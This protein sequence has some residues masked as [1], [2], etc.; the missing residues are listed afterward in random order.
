MINKTFRLFISSTFSDFLSER[1]LL[2]DEVFPIVDAY[3]QNRG[4][5]FQ[6]IDLRWGI[7]TE[8]A[9][10]Q[11]TISICLDEVERCTT[12]SPRPNFLVMA[13][14]RYGW[15]PLPY[16]IRPDD[17]NDI[18]A[19]ASNNEKNLLDEWYLYDSN[20]IGG[21]YYLKERT[22]EYIDDKVWFI[23]EKEL[24]DTLIRL[25]DLIDDK[26]GRFDSYKMSATEHEIFAGLFNKI[27]QGDSVIAIF[28]TGFPDKDESQEKINNVKR[29]IEERLYSVDCQE[30]II[31]LEWN[32]NYPQ[33]FIERISKILLD[34]IK[35]EIE[36]LE[37]IKDDEDLLE[38]VFRKNN[39]NLSIDKIK[40]ETIQ[41]YVDGN[42]N[43]PLFV[44][45]ESGSG[46]STI[47]SEFVCR[48]ERNVF[49]SFFGVGENS[50]T[51]QDSLRLICNKIK[52]EIGVKADFNI[53]K[54]NITEKIHDLLHSISTKEKIV[55][56]L[57]GFDS[58]YD[59]DE[60]HETVL[61]EV[62]PDNVKFIVS[63]AE[64]SVYEKFYIKDSPIL[65]IDKFDSEKSYKTVEQLLSYTNRCISNTEQI[66]CIK[67]SVEKGA[68]PLQIKLLSEIAS[69]WHSVENVC[70][71]PNDARKIVHIY[72]TDMYKKYGH[73][74]ELL[75]CSLAL[76]AI[77]PFGITVEALLKL[78]F[79]F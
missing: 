13:G 66:E 36:R 30:N 48:T 62:L 77:A 23:K 74:K 19:N 68:T 46:K 35:K 5:N 70:D 7:N 59:I 14:E 25:V 12:L 9:L 53:T 67:K 39:Q 41:T 72:I 24:Q 34:N 60:I 55:I 44:V 50:Y 71:L 31:E 78:L 73:N 52:K 33:F 15:V 51:L 43:K 29:R 21:C 20:E 27:E 1:N 8:S 40:L 61:P 32:E 69:V 16:R 65:L 22:D 79:P 37:S 56:I 3:C 54:N 47:L 26:T 38:D 63:I 17:Y 4:Y 18:C 10:N 2:N 6:L 42:E 57:D 11:K 45:G 75:L 28:R 76:I 49:F 58:F 64:K